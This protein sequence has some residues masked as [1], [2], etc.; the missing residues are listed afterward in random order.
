MLRESSAR[1]ISVIWESICCAPNLPLRVIH[2]TF[3]AR[4]KIKPMANPF[5]LA[6]SPTP[7]T[8]RQHFSFWLCSLPCERHHPLV[9]SGRIRGV[10][11]RS[12]CFLVCDRCVVFLKSKGKAIISQNRVL[13]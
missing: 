3:K 5:P 11:V 1:F 10:D 9:H 6:F 12:Q 4:L 7:P 2:Q 8:R 13:V